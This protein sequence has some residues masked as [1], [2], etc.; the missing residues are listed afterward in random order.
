MVVV[1]A[2]VELVVVCV[3]E[4]VIEAVVVEIGVLVDVDE[5]EE[6]TGA[7][8]LLEL[9]FLLDDFRHVDETGATALT[10]LTRHRTGCV[11]GQVGSCGEK[12]RSLTPAVR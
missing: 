11:S 5:L 3:V 6:E 4:I 8:V 9:E 7:S 1:E 10:A 12:Q 2:G